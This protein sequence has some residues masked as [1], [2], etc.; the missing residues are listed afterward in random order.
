MHP[1]EKAKKR[2]KNLQEPVFSLAFG[3]FLATVDTRQ[4]LAVDVNRLFL[5]NNFP[6]QV[7]THK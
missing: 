1:T 4:A 6:F 3:P 5:I 2:E 7:I